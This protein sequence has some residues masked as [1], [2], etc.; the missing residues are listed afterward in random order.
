MGGGLPQHIFF[1]GGSLKYSLLN[2][3][4]E[5]NISFNFERERGGVQSGYKG[6]S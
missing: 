1:G 6:D 3:L 2:H 4:Y 5:K